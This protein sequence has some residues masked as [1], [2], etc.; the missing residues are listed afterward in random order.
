MDILW[1]AILGLIQGLT[2]FLPISS[3]GHIALLSKLFRI[4]L[5]DELFFNVCLHVG[6]LAAI[7]V[8]FKKEIRDL[9]LS[10]I[11]GFSLMTQ[12][13]MLAEFYRTDS[14]LQLTIHLLIATFVTGL[15]GLMA[16]TTV[17]LSF[18]SFKGMAVGWWITGT[19]LL[20]VQ[21]KMRHELGSLKFLWYHATWIGLFQSFALFPGISRAGATLAAGL[22]IGLDRNQ[23][24]RFA[25]LLAVPTIF[26]AFIGEFYFEK[27]A[28]LS[29]SSWF[30]YFVGFIVSAIFSYFALWLL[31]WLLERKQFIPFIVYSYVLGTFVWIAF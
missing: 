1:A 25:F 6:S 8:Y 10:C 30:P 9:A 18:H 20:C 23:S 11:R 7:F 29:V 4:S 16:H 15:I 19:L 5:T 27:E 31:Q 13:R 21:G 26:M 22:L 14:S 2:E 12:P 24:F 28:I 3:S 17:T